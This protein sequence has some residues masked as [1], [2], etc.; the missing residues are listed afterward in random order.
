ME[1]DINTM[2]QNFAKKLGL[3]IPESEIYT[4]KIDSS[5]F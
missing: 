1:I 5:S 4:Q 2:N 3:Y